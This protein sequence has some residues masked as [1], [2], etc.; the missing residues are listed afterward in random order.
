MH[1]ERRIKFGVKRRTL[2]TRAGRKSYPILNRISY[3]CCNSGENPMNSTRLCR[4]A[5]VSAALGL[6]VSSVPA[7][8]VVRT[9]TGAA[10]ADITATRDAFRTDLGG[11]TTAGAN[12]SFGGLR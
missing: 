8:V 2:L 12:G 3:K 7:Q 5:I 10:A 4:L 1:V 6:F 9:A 11:G